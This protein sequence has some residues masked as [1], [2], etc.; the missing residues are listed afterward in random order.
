MVRET[1]EAQSQGQEVGIFKKAIETLP[2][3]RSPWGELNASSKEGEFL[4]DFGRDQAYFGLEI[5][6]TYRFLPLEVFASETRRILVSLASRQKEGEVYHEHWVFTEGMESKKESFA[7]SGVEIQEK[8]PSGHPEMVSYGAKDTTPLFLILAD[9]YL[10]VSRDYDLLSKIWP[11]INS[12][13]EAINKNLYLTSRLDNPAGWMDAA[14]ALQ[15]L[16]GQIPQGELSLAENQDLKY[17]ANFRW[18]NRLINMD[19]DKTF[20][21]DL[22]EE[23]EGLR[24]AF[25]R[26]FWVD[27]EG[28]VVQAVDE[29]GAKRGDIVST[30]AETLFGGILYEYYSPF[31]VSRVREKDLWTPWG[32]R[33]RSSK[34]VNFNQVDKYQS[35]K[36][37]IAPSNWKIQQGFLR[38]GYLADAKELTDNCLSVFHYFQSFPENISYFDG[39]D[40]PVVLGQSNLYQVWDNGAAMS[41]AAS[42]FTNDERLFLMKVLPEFQGDVS[43]AA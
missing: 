29:N 35:G 33:T 39:Q 11:N 21:E 22:I 14:D 23:S 32:I 18:G 37:W 27:S 38:Y 17:N 24:Q 4:G 10:R 40:Y 3:Y 2:L 8:G 30:G 13:L 7:E 19:I 5:I 26:D 15:D 20:G 6:D 1:L 28:Y 31:V 12:A 9:E 36:I 43:L 41:F 42:K 16:N 34:S 25:N